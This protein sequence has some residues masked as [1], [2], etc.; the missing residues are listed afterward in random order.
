MSV[1]RRSLRVCAEYFLSAHES[2]SG[3]YH[4][5]DDGQTKQEPTGDDGQEELTGGVDDHE[6]VE[7]TY[8]DH[9]EYQGEH[10]EADYDGSEQYADA[11]EYPGAHEDEAVAREESDQFV[12]NDESEPLP[13]PDP[14][15]KGSADFEPTEDQEHEGDEGDEAS[16]DAEVTSVITVTTHANETGFPEDEL[17]VLTEVRDSEVTGESHFEEFEGRSLLP[18][19]FAFI[20]LCP[21]AE[22]QDLNTER[23]SSG[24]ISGD[25]A[26][27]FTGLSH[28]SCSCAI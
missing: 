28:P 27:G 5:N 3:Y 22:R 4:V 7:S 25:E 6:D 23:S 14:T 21:L 20:H 2:D 12:T 16:G 13:D 10:E 9:A 15:Y 11:Q 19:P 26:D 8:S 1:S 24:S 17:R 18:M